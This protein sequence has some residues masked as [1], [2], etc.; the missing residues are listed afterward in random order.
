MLTGKV[1]RKMMITNQK[2]TSFLAEGMGARRLDG[3]RQKKAV[4]VQQVEN[5]SWSST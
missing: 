1:Q 2:R 4:A 3:E 5:H